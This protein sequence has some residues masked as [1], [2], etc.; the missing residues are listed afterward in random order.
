MCKHTCNEAITVEQRHIISSMIGN[1]CEWYDYVIY[2]SLAPILSEVFFPKTDK[3]V[4]LILAF[5]IFAA[6]FL[7]RPIGGIVFGHLSDKYGR[8]FAFIRSILLMA[9]PALAIGLLPSYDSIGRLAPLLLLLCRLMQGVAVGGEYPTI[10]TYIA[11]L[12]PASRRGFIGSFINVTTVTGV[13]LATIT[14]AVITQ[15]LSHDALLEYGWR[16]PFY[17]SFLTIF[18]GYYVRLRL[19]ESALF[20]ANTTKHKYP[21]LD[22]LKT[23]KASIAKIFFYTISLAIAYYTFNIFAMTYF[24]V[25]LQL[26]YITALYLS[27]VSAAVLIV[28]IPVVGY[29]SDRFGR[30]AVT[31]FGLGCLIVAIYPIYIGFAQK[32]LLL[33]VICQLIFAVV[34]AL[35]IAPLPTLIAEQ[36]STNARCSSVALGYNWA[37]A[38]FGGTAPVVNMYFISH[39][40]SELAPCFYLMVTGIVS[41]IAAYFMRDLTGKELP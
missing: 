35:C 25:S 13:L 9:I 33:A 31:L 23:A 37:Q 36:V 32:T 41:F 19:P 10:V 14:V 21:L 34:M 30:K 24:T 22:A 18:L 40:N 15:G 1:A 8:K 28:L 7:V 11:E 3:V 17:I 12:A 26:T 39:F 27:I 29:C 6:G 16:I 5:A 38:L 4:S 20:A 2:G